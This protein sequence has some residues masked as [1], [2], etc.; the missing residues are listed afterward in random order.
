MEVYHI[1]EAI[2]MNI[3]NSKKVPLSNGKVMVEPDVIL[4]FLDRIRAIL[5]EELDTARLVLTEKERIVKDAFAEAEQYMENSRFQ[6]AQ[7]LDENEI[8]QNAKRAGEEIIAKAED[9]A[10]D[11]RRDANEYASEILHHAE[12]VLQKS[13]EAVSR[14]RDEINLALK[15]HDY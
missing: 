8:T 6:V 15:N 10:L 4:D 5:P 1:L 13:L 14:G 7:L 9:F 3:K 11:V 12:M 2:E